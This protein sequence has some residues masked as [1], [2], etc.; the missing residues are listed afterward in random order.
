MG[1]DRGVDFSG[2]Y[3]YAQ[4][5]TESWGNEGAVNIN[6]VRNHLANQQHIRIEEPL[7]EE[8]DT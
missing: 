4:E 7:E 8:S 5:Q 1:V 3:Q 2:V 6:V